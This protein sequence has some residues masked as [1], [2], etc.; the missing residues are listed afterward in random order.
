M[1]AAAAVSIGWATRISLSFFFSF[2]PKIVSYKYAKKITRS[3]NVK[4]QPY[5]FNNKSNFV[6]MFILAWKFKLKH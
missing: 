6:D 5:G 3:S 1:H 4:L 2:F